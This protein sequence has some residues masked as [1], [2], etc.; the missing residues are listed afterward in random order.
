MGMMGIRTCFIRLQ[1]MI[2]NAWYAYV[3]LHLQIEM[4]SVD[5]RDYATNNQCSMVHIPWKSHESEKGN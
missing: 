5:V 4:C 3:V 1:H 2:Y